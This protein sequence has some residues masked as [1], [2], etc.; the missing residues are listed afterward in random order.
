M[1]LNF[2][3]VEEAQR[4]LHRGCTRGCH[5]EGGVCGQH[6]LHARHVHLLVSETWSTFTSHI[7]AYSRCARIDSF[8]LMNRINSDQKETLAR[9]G[10]LATPLSGTTAQQMK[11]TWSHGTQQGA[12][13]EIANRPRGL[14]RAANLFEPRQPELVVEVSCF[15]GGGSC[16]HVGPQNCFLNASPK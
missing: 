15:L 9:S 13:Q 10:F 3:P 5:V 14:P 7:F 8:F 6:L 16:W 1:Y 2:F 11:C 4:L 12:T